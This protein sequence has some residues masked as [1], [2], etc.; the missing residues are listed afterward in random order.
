[1]NEL[2]RC[3]GIQ[4]SFRTGE[5]RQHV[6]RGIDFE[7]GAGEMVSLVGPSGAGK[8]TLLHILGLLDRADQGEIYLRGRRVDD[9]SAAQKARIRN[10]DIGFVFQF[11]HL[12]PELTALQNVLLS[13]M[14]LH[15]QPACLLDRSRQRA[16]AAESLRRMGRSGH[17]HKRPAKL[18]GG[19]RQRVAIARALFAEPELVLCDEPTGN[20]DR[21]TAGEIMRLLF[22]INREKGTAFVFVT[23]DERLARLGSRQV[24]LIDGRIGLEPPGGAGAADLVIPILE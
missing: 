20:L 23:H 14:L 16:R 21:G 11:Y 5:G 2:L 1:M 12:V 3:S 17:L 18:S 6:L 19:E 9:L 4:R 7:V 10:Q 13:G 24:H 8:S 22:E 15:S